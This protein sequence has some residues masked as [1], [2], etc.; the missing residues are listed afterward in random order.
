MCVCAST[1]VKKRVEII[2]IID[3]SPAYQED[4]D[5][6]MA[7]I[8][9]EF[10]ISIS[11]PHS[12]RIPEVYHLLDQKYWVAFHNTQ[13]AGTIGLKLFSNNNAILVR[14]MVDK[15][16]R[17]KEYRTASL[18]LEQSISWALEKKVKTIYLGTMKQF[19]AAQKFY[20]KKGFSEIKKED[21]PTDYSPNPIDTLF[22]KIQLA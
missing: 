4:I 2:K 19:V 8:A 1:S 5:R 15:K 9:K 21:L 14:M 10:P 20:V 7:G 6:M 17:G 12:T 3:Y 13:V 16:Y 22:Y 11:S 18:L